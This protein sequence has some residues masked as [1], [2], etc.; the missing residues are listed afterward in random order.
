MAELDPQTRELLDEMRAA[1][2]P[3]GSALSPSGARRLLVEFADVVGPAEPPE[4][5]A[6]EAVRDL[7]VPGPNGGVPVRLYRPA[8]AGPPPVLVYYHG[9]GW[10]VGS[11]EARDGVCRR[12]AADVGALVVSV[13]YRLAP[14]H[15]F[16]E[17]LEDAHAAARWAVDNAAAIGGDPD[18][19]GVVGDSAGGNLAAAVAL[20]A[21]DAGGPDL[22]YQSLI[23]PVVDSAMDT[24]S[25]DEYAEGYFLGR[26]KMAWYWDRYAPGPIDRANPYAAPLRAPDLADLPP[27]TVLTAEF[28]PLRDEGRAYADRL[29]AAGVETE[30]LRFDDAMH[31]VLAFYGRLDRAD[32]LV[33]AVA[34]GA[35]SALVD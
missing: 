8:A 13:E 33:D 1:G 35:R 5:P 18:R 4:A 3:P 16:P 26:E 10:V 2:V 24:D 25:Y 29:E 21:R 17:P 22:A 14:E 30:H 9:G 6:L 27:A 32:D 34:A 31:G 11:V 7:E 20:L 12:L 19:V 28:D 23:Y 15:P